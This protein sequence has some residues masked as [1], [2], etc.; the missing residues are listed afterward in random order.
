M[1]KSVFWLVVL[2]LGCALWPGVALSQEAKSKLVARPVP[3]VVDVPVIEKG[4]R[5]GD[6][7]GAPIV[8]GGDYEQCMAT[9][10]LRDR[11]A[12]IAHDP[13]SDRYFV[14]SDGPGLDTGCTFRADGPLRIKVKV[15]RYAGPT[16]GNGKLENIDELVAA[17]LICKYAELILPAY[18]VDYDAEPYEDWEGRLI[19]PERDQIFFNGDNM[20]SLHGNNR[21]FLYGK[22]GQWWRNKFLIPIDKIKFP[23]DPGPLWDGPEPAENEIRINIDV[24]NPGVQAWCMAIDWA[25]IKIDIMSPI[26][27][28]HGNGSDPDFWED[29]GF[30]E[31]LDDQHL[32][33]NNQIS[34]PAAPIRTNANYLKG[35]IPRIVRSFGVDSVHVVVHSKGG[36]DT[37]SYLANHYDVNG[38]F[39][40][41]S[42][43]S[44]STPHDG[45]ILADLSV[46]RKEKKKEGHVRFSSDWPNWINA[47]AMVGGM[48]D[49][50]PDLQVKRCLGRNGFNDGNVWGLPYGTVYQTIGADAD[51]NGNHEIDNWDEYEGMRAE[52]FMLRAAWTVMWGV[53]TGAMDMMYQILANTAEVEAVEDGQWPVYVG[54]GMPIYVPAFRIDRIPTTSFL[55]NDLMVT[56]QSSMG[57]GGNFDFRVTAVELFQT[58]AEA[59]DHAT[60]ANTATA[61]VVGPWLINIERQDGDLNPQY[62]AP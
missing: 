61:N 41:L 2:Y 14:E 15:D 27:L 16:D 62:P 49:G 39:D 12:T 4:I 9:A 10:G 24:S 7:L 1:R 54:G 30:T 57:R 56:L 47:M 51:N 5:P 28:V 6:E 44:L 42:F 58:N 18:D 55:E 59:R 25:A 40:I 33:W 37:R 26:I 21:L 45:S 48:D 20:R 31:G 38:D 11:A 35:R 46:V 3:V 36:L 13:P 32:L 60:V 19:L 8:R 52:S 53:T 34:M 17:G 43:T 23:D 29:M 50:R 22:D